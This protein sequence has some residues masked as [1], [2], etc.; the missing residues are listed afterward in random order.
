MKTYT[1][2]DNTERSVIVRDGMALPCPTYTLE[3][4]VMLID[5]L[6]GFPV[7]AEIP[8]TQ[9][10]LGAPTVAKAIELGLL[11]ENK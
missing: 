8:G 6:K 3:R 11:V 10:A 4:A 1:H 7:D 5:T 9:E 2:K